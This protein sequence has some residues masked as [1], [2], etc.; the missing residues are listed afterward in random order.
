MNNFDHGRR[1]LEYLLIGERL[2]RGLS[3]N[4]FGVGKDGEEAAGGG[5][6]G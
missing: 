1:H 4:F 3:G 6:G 5:E 2:G